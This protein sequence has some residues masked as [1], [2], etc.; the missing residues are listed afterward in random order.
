[1]KQSELID[2][3]GL[4]STDT[5]MIAFFQKHQIGKLPKSITPNQGS[6]CIIFKPM[7]ISFWFGYDIKNDRLQPPVSPRNDNYKFVA[8]LRC[9]MFT[10]VDDSLKTPDPKPQ[11]FWDVI[12]SPMY[13]PE[14][15]EGL[16]GGP[17][18]RNDYETTFDMSIGTDQLLK[19]RYTKDKKKNLMC[20]SWIA[21]MEQSEIINRVFF[22]ATYTAEDFPFIRRAYTCVIKWL[23]DSRFLQMDERVYEGGLK[24]E[25]AEILD[26]VHHH[27]KGHLWAN[28]IISATGLRSFL[29]TVTT[30]RSV[31]D[32]QGNKIPFYIRDII[33]E[34]TGHK[35]EFEVR[36]DQDFG[37]IDSFLNDIPFDS[38][39]YE[40]VGNAL[41]AKLEIYKKL[42][43]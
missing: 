37:T 40:T 35:R 3:L 11:D 7:N 34:C 23:Y 15:I 2:L 17:S 6:K 8:Y 41:T 42:K 21:I 28:Q 20:T 39:V 32:E 27:L 24:G 43:G 4:P 31:K 12:P 1:M 16:M 25:T 18:E 36:Y 33:L 14:K 10:H 5:S 30:N 29:Y 22:N 38:K 13:A 19:V 9:I 26:F